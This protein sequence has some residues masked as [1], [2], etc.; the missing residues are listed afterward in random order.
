MLREG[1][2]SRA[3]AARTL[4]AGTG[5][6]RLA[7]IPG[8]PLASTAA[9][10]HRTVAGLPRHGPGRPGRPGGLRSEARAG[11][12][13]TQRLFRRAVAA[14]RKLADV[15]EA[16]GRLTAGN[17]G[18]CEQCGSPI[19][20][21]LLQ[22][23]PRPGTARVAQPCPLQRNDTLWRGKQVTA[24]PSTRRSAAVPGGDAEPTAAATGRA[25]RNRT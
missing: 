2:V 10:G 13:E 21:G 7:G 9:R 17:F 12:Q 15:E 18:Y 25:V 24:G 23:L 11:T 1:Y 3:G 20:A 14:R 8:G 22:A 6:P 4:P 5:G 16:L 19:P